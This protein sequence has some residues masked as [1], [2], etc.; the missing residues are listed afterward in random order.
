MIKK[1]FDAAIVTI[2]PLAIISI[3]GYLGNWFIHSHG[4]VVFGPAISIQDQVFYCIDINNYE[5]ITLD[6]IRFYIPKEVDINSIKASSFMSSKLLES[7]SQGDKRNIIVISG[8]QPD[9]MTRLFIPINNNA[10]SSMIDLINAAEMKLDIRYAS[11]VKSSFRAA[12]RDAIVTAI[13]YSILIFCSTLYINDR[14][15]K[16]Q[17]KYDNNINETKNDL[18]KEE[19]K[20]SK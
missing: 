14:N 4:E 20:W 17:I 8:I 10:P 12:V 5:N 7:T 3:L 19:E 6:G 18:K 15:G 16:R 2:V 11:Q 1:F 13:L 9:S